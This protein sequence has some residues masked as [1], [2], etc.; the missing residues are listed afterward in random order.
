M[1]VRAAASLYQRKRDDSNA[2]MCLDQALR[3]EPSD[4]GALHHKA[5]A[6]LN[7]YTPAKSAQMLSEAEACIDAALAQE[8]RNAGFLTVKGR[9]RFEMNHLEESLPVL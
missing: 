7:L 4:K 9:S 2:L 1:R 6:L 3:L 5:A 8:P